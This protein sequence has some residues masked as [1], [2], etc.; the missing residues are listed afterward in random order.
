M[1][2]R[3]SWPASTLLLVLLMASICRAQ[4]PPSP[5][6]KDSDNVEGSRVNLNFAP[7]RP[8]LRATVNQVNN[9]YAVNSHD[10]TVE[11]FLA[12]GGT[13]PIDVF[14]VPWGP[15]SIATWNPAQGPRQLLVVCRGSDCLARLDMNTGEVIG[16]VDLPAEPADILVDP[17]RNL[18]WVSCAGADA[19]VE[20]NLVND[21]K[22]IYS[23]ETNPTF[24]MKRPTFLSFDSTGTSGKIMVA[25]LLS[26]NSSTAQGGNQPNAFEDEVYDTENG[27]GNNLPDEDLFRIDPTRPVASGV[28]VIAKDMGTILFA[29]GIHPITGKY[30]QLNTE[31]DNKNPLRQN[32]ILVKGKFVNNRINII[33]ISAAL[34][35]DGT[36]DSGSTVG[37][38]DSYSNEAGIPPGLG[39][40]ITDAARNTVGQPYAL[41]FHP[42]NGYV[43]VA[44]LLTNNILVLDQNG[45][46]VK[47]FDLPAGAIPRGVGLDASGTVLD[48]Y[49]WGTNQILSYR[50]ALPTPT[51]LKTFNLKN[52]PTPRNVAGGRRIF[53]DASFSQHKNMSCASCHVEGTTDL[54]AW[55]LSNPPFDSK[56][57]MMTQTLVGL[58]RL[59]PFHWRG[60]RS[61]ADF[62][63][64]FIGLL[65][66]DRK[67]SPLELDQFEEFI[68]SL[69]V[70]A[71]PIQ[72]PQRIIN[73]SIL[74]DLPAGTSPADPKM[75][76]SRFRRQKTF[77]VLTCNDCH[78]APTGTNN[79]MNADFNIPGLPRLATF[80][81]APF[82]D[83]QF[84][85]QTTVD[86]DFT[87]SPNS[88]TYSRGYLGG[89]IAHSGLSA[90]LFDFIVLITGDKMTFG[91]QTGW[92]ITSFVN[93]WDHGLAPAVH[94]A[95]VLNAQTT[96]TNDFTY[97]NQQAN[98]G[99]CDVVIS[100]KSVD[101]SSS[102][103]SARWF[104]DRNLSRFVAD[105]VGFAP[106]T[107][108]DFLNN[109]AQE[110]NLFFGVP[111]GMG[112]RIGVDFDMDG[113]L[114]GSDLE[115]LTPNLNLNDS[116]GPAF[117]VQPHVAF[118]TT[119]V[120]RL[121]WSTNE[122]A[123][124]FVRYREVGAN[125]WINM[126]PINEYNK[127]Q[128]VVLNQLRPSTAEAFENYV[129]EDVEYQW[130]VQVTDRAGNRTTYASMAA[131]RI[132]T[133]SFIKSQWS[134]PHREGREKVEL[135]AH[136]VVSTTV[137]VGPD[138]S[139]LRLVT[140]EVKV[141]M[142]RGTDAATESLG[143]NVPALNRIVIG[144]VLVKKAGSRRFVDNPINQVVTAGANTGLLSTVELYDLDQTGAPIVHSV[145]PLIMAENR[146]PNVRH[147]AVSAH[148]RDTGSNNAGNVVL[149]LWVSNLASGDEVAFN[150]EAVV[151]TNRPGL[152]SMNFPANPVLYTFNHDSFR[153]W[154]LPD[155]GEKH[156]QASVQVP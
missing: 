63:G 137:T 60:E 57:P 140:A 147:I 22:R 51:I 32:E 143:G 85:K 119:R 20:I 24:R 65:G 21:A 148:T 17:G 13:E 46:Y 84:K 116:T 23:E 112:E 77:G 154:S 90:T 52:D 153:Q 40:A 69:Q 109:Q 83:L 96:N 149:N 118:K 133:D 86:V 10:N 59:P 105:Q 125:S 25:P 61:L 64:A 53:Y 26:G 120:A 151:Q 131:E 130:E 56:R 123:K 111:V 156:A 18:A 142:K 19:L 34:P 44:G 49:C 50:W 97:L 144:R 78:A 72:D 30:W 7:V 89:H 124:T 80:K 82:H 117:V 121:S 132:R 41:T 107:M 28:T 93:Q 15:V 145:R 3:Y 12:G 138:Q 129:A 92:D 79:D 128:S 42:S 102:L 48:V 81:V 74:A 38:L 66:N 6:Y 110:S 70:P 103:V 39:G 152:Y 113:I 87:N 100:G 67:L 27:T 139:G 127:I 62:N 2:S 43:F 36:D 76:Q 91:N 114:N 58:D 9:L 101:S 104:F 33:D 16:I 37:I 94:F 31:A 141:R 95:R 11:V 108:A 47:E 134:D 1:R 73:N 29:H 71:N 136:K 55:N 54:L 122:P 45:A 75:G 146:F 150:V 8:F 14:G 98:L 68:F 35:I 4:N 155:G 106:R 88:P 99:N 126:K 135:G 115:P 5:N